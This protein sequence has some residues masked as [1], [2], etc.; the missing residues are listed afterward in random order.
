MPK[1]IKTCVRC[2]ASFSVYPSRVK[3][4]EARGIEIKFCS[5]ACTAAAR[6]EGLI[7]SRPREGE[8]VPCSTCG[9]M[10]YLKQYK[11][12]KDKLHFCSQRCRT[13]AISEGR[14]DRKFEQAR[15]KKMTGV[16]FNCCI[17]GKKKYQRKSYAARDVD[18][19]CGSPV[20]FSAYARSKWGL[21]PC[22]DSHRR[23]SG[24][25][26]SPKRNSNFT[27]KQR[28]AWLEKEC[29]RCGATE[30]LCL[31]HIL[32]DCAGGKA[33]REN[34]QTLCQPCN[35]WKAKHVDMPLARAMNK[36]RKAA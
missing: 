9:K 17:C 5:K 29:A 4:Q 36:L 18:K 15:V 31:D 33:T 30:N 2:D 19:T 7:G 24:R 21:D 34:A 16:T 20:C 27:A 1:I 14:V 22:P 3:W 25:K 28:K 12:N 35:N 6:A 8:E 32:A 23:K 10:I 13:K 26:M 11:L